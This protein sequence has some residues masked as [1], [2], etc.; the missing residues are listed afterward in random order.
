MRYYKTL[1]Q[2]IVKLVNNDEN[3]KYIDINSYKS[4][5]YK[6]SNKIDD[7]GIDKL[8]SINNLTINLKKH[9]HFFEPQPISFPNSSEYFNEK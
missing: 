8:A 3:L 7:E 4:I 5:K 2:H 9:H 1:K 6:K